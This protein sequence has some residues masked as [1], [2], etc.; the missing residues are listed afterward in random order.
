[1]IR[2]HT[3]YCPYVSGEH[4]ISVEYQEVNMTGTLQHTYLKTEY[5]CSMIS[6]CTIEYDPKLG[7]PLFQDAAKQLH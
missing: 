2:S 1:M 7:C 5:D 4:T 3:G 6:E